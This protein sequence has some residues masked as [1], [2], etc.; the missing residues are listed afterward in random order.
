MESLGELVQTK[1][2]RGEALTPTETVRLRAQKAHICRLAKEA[3]ELVY[4]QS[5]ASSIHRHVPIQRIFRDI[6]AARCM[7]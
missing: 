2:E 7:R 1:A 3:V 6:E 5:G 4:S